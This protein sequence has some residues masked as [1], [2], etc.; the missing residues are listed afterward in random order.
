MGVL[1]K[2]VSGLSQGSVRSPLGKVH[3]HQRFLSGAPGFEEA[4]QVAALTQLGDL[5]RDPPRTGVPVPF[6]VSVALDLAQW[7]PRALRRPRDHN[8]LAQRLRDGS[9]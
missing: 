2:R 5:Q 3:C 7:R 6:P 9:F 4:G 8:E 1:R